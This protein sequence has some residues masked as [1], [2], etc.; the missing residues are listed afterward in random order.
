MRG[1]INGGPLHA[2]A[3]GI[4]SILEKVPFQSPCLNL[5]APALMKLR[6]HTGQKTTLKL[7][8]LSCCLEG[9]TSLKNVMACQSQ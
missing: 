3:Y 2:Y 1:H 7:K 4:L 9:A 8:G 5:S 6:M